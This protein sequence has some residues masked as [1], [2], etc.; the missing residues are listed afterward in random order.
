[1]E[2]TDKLAA[3]G[4]LPARPLEPPARRVPITR[5]WL[6]GLGLVLLT[7]ATFAPLALPGYEFVNAD[8][9]DYVSQNPH[10]LGGLTRAN[11]RWACTTLYAHNW[12]PL[13]WL[14]LQF[15]AQLFGNSPEAYHRTSLVLHLL[16]VL[17]LFLALEKLTQRLWRSALVAALFAIHPLHVESVAWVSERKD[18]LSGCFGMLTLLAYAYYARRASLARYLAVLVSFGL[19]LLAKPMLVTLP[20]VLL[21]LDFWPLGRLSSGRLRLVIEKVPLLALSAAS[22]AMTVVAQRRIV[23]DAGEF[24]VP[25]RVGNALVSYLRYA[26]KTIW[27][28]DLTIFYPHPLDTLSPLAIAAAAL[29]LAAITVLTLRAWRTRAY[30]LTGWLWYVGVLVPVIGLVQVGNQA[31]ADRYTYLPL[32]GLFIILA[33]GLA[34]LVSARHGSPGL[35]TGMAVAVIAA[36]AILTHVQLGY[37]R[38]SVRLWQHD[39]E[40]TAP[41]AISHFYLADGLEAADRP[42]EALAQYQEAL[43]LAP[44]YPEAHLRSGR[45]LEAENRPAEARSEFE[46]E[47]RQHPTSADAHGALGRLD[48]RQGHFREAYDRYRVALQLEENPAERAR[49][50]HILQRLDPGRR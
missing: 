22:S 12:H 16:N 11:V 42:I 8:D 31:L 32:V 19:G 44:Y 37:W 3:G 7:A 15:D 21:V 27:P 4:A 14:S 25:I 20:C 5:I 47:L 6:V 10:V 45:I 43:R 13:T 38:N 34:D 33:W 1:M 18:V 36:C 41:H 49:L 2:Q 46:K 35:A 40:V 50:I 28:S 26:R 24:P 23:K 39:I 17:L 48:E 30:L 29:L 9:K